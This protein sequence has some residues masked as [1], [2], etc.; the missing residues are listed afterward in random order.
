MAALTP[1]VGPGRDV[2]VMESAV[3]VPWRMPFRAPDPCVFRGVSWLQALEIS[4]PLTG[5]TH[6]ASAVYQSGSIHGNA[7]TRMPRIGSD[8]TW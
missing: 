5:I 2:E 7:W 8:S 4:P 6:S 1:L 3:R